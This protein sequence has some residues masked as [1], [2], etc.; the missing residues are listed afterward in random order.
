MVNSIS[1]FES[2]KKI[3]SPIF[4]NRRTGNGIVD[5]FG[6]GTARM[7]SS[8]QTYQSLAAGPPGTFPY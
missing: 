8:F 3:N 1:V 7:M 5:S 6:I 2:K 4:F